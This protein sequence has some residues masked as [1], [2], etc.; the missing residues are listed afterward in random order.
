MASAALAKIRAC[1]IRALMRQTGL[2]QHTIEKIRDG[3][4]VRRATLQ[5][6]IA[7]VQ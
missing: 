6:V 1:G 3:P 7:A 2:S 4:P 5:R